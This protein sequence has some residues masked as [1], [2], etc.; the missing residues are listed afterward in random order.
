M[1][2]MKTVARSAA[3]RKRDAKR[4]RATRE[5]KERDATVAAIV[6]HW[7]ATGELTDERTIANWRERGVM[8][9]WHKT[10][11]C[12]MPLAQFTPETGMQLLR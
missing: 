10:T 11:A 4:R 6:E 12:G 1:K 7:I 3:S 5:K 2:N 9:P 8:P